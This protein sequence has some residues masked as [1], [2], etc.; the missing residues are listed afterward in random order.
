MLLVQILLIILITALYIMQN[1]FSRLY[2]DNY[3]SDKSHASPILAI[4]NGVAVPLCALFF[5]GFTFSEFNPTTL[6]LGLA[7]AIVLFFYYESLIRASATGSY[8]IMMVFNVGG[9]III[10]ALLSTLAFGADFSYVKLIAIIIIVVAVYLV[11]LR[12]S[13]DISSTASGSHS[14]AL[15]L[16]ICAVLAV[17]NGTYATLFDAQRLFAPG[18]SQGHMMI[19]YTFGGAGLLSFV[20]LLVTKKRETLSAFR[21]TKRS[22]G[23]LIGAVTVSALAANVLVLLLE[24]EIDMTLMVTFDNAGVMVGSALVS[25]LLFK[26]RLTKVNIIGICMMTVALCM[27]GG[28]AVIES[29]IAGLFG[30]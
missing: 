19:I 18:D 30:A 6:V 5:S 4:C 14:V 10:P 15:F 23:F 28:S 12:K 7:N 17:A 16:V 13:E 2:T 8:S 22:L 9:G 26:E 25:A 3:P 20:R 11:T 1:L 21:Q 24:L 27:S 29:F